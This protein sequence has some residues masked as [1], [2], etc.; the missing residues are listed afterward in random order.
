MRTWSE[1]GLRAVLP[2]G[3]RVRLDYLRF[4]GLSRIFPNLPWSPAVSRLPSPA[5]AGWHSI[6]F[7]HN[8]RLCFIKG[9]SPL[10]AGKGRKCP[11]LTLAGQYEVWAVAAMG[12]TPATRTQS[13][14]PTGSVLPRQTET[15]TQQLQT[16]FRNSPMLHACNCLH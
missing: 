4:Q 15:N 11:P 9:T 8:T 7:L 16:S 14:S 3:R 2:N 10:K 5:N 12:G 6:G 13:N 1:W